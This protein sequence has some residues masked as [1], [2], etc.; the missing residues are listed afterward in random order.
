M[1]PR[2]TEGEV[3]AKSLRVTGFEFDLLRLTVFYRLGFAAV[4][5]VVLVRS[6]KIHTR[7]PRYPNSTHDAAASNILFFFCKGLYPPKV[8]VSPVIT[9]TFIDLEVP[10]WCLNG[11]VFHKVPFRLPKK[12]SS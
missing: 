7:L 1:E 5:L 6:W 9:I 10:P 11:P 12:N 4:D 2:L 3:A 8:I